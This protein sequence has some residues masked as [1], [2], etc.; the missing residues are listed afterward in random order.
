MWHASWR[1]RNAFEVLMGKHEGMRT[2]GRLGIDGRIILIFSR[3]TH[4]NDY[5]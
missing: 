3:V 2:H 4:R 5:I 1:R